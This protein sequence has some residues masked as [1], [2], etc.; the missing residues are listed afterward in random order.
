MS[1]VSQKDIAEQLGLSIA[2]VSR[3]LRRD[4]SIP[5]E[6]TA[7]VITLA[8]RIGYR[9]KSRELSYATKAADSGSTDSLILAAF[10][11]AEDIHDE[12]N[13][14]RVVA[15]MSKAAHGLCASLVLHTIP[16]GR[17]GLI[18]L[19]ENHP[20]LMRAGKVQGVVLVNAF[21]ADTV[22]KLTRQTTCVGVDVQYPGVRMDYVGEENVASIGKILAHLK[23]LGHR[24]IG[25]VDWKSWASTTEERLA[26]FLLSSVRGDCEYHP[27]WILP[28]QNRTGDP[29]ELDCLEKWISEG[30]TALVCANDA[31][32]VQ[33]YRRLR[34]HGYSCPKDVSITGFDDCSPLSDV[35]PLTSMRVHFQ[36]LGRMAVERLV[37]RIQHPTLPVTRM[38][39]EC[40]LLERSTTG[41]AR[42][43]KI[44][45]PLSGTAK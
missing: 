37:A 5:P 16:V 33:V 7:R 41:P 38:L 18:H 8:S 6:T 23:G 24:K 44:N 12:E 29:G 36:D 4:S 35:P 32:A 10:V 3:C 43:T 15:G 45:T 26:G 34:D 17:K 13:T 25:Y 27:E 28:R 22:Q 1:T 42:Q 40:E 19:P 9:P 21:D 2:T 20:E 31:V 11:Q 39:V 14:F 30:V